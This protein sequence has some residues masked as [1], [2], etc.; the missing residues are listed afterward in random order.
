MGEVVQNTVAQAGGGDIANMLL[1]MGAM[2]AIVYFM[3]LRPQRKQQQ[4]HQSLLSALKKGDDVVLSSG[5]FGKVHAVEERTVVVEIGDK[6]RI[7][8]L[9]SAVSGLASQ[10]LTSGAPSADAQKNSEK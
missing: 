3:L 10:A 2:F 5:I 9:K 7:K 4:E 8:V 6:T 1:M